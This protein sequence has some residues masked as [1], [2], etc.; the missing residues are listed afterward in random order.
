VPAA[1]QPWAAAFPGVFDIRDGH[2]TTSQLNGPGLGISDEAI[3][4]AAR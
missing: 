3:A 1:N 4:R 2:M